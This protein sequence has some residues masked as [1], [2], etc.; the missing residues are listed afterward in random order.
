MNLDQ[1]KLTDWELVQKEY[2]LVS[3]LGKGSFGTVLEAQHLS[4]GKRVA[5]KLIKFEK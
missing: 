2:K 5:I 4:T 1:V 3:S